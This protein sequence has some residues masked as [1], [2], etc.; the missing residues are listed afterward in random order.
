MSER[1][2][3]LGHQLAEALPAGCNVT[4]HHLSS[5]PT[6]CPALFA[7][8]PGDTPPKTFCESQ[9]LVVSIDPTPC[10]QPASDDDQVLVF[11]IEVLIYC[12]T[13]LTTLF[14][15]KADSS[16]YLHL[17]DAP[18]T[19]TAPLKAIATTFI[20]YLGQE[21]RR[22]GIKTV[23]SL[24]ARAQDQYL[25]PG[26]VENGGKHVLDDRGLIRWWCR[27]LD[28]LLPLDDGEERTL[29]LQGYVLVPGLD[30]H[31]TSTLFPPSAKLDA[32]DRK[33]WLHGHP[34]REISRT[35]T[36]PPR[37]LVP[38]FPDDPKA[39]Y[40]DEL[41]E[42]VSDSLKTGLTQSP[43]KLRR[44]GQWLGIKTLEQF[45]ETM[46]FRQEC[47]S[48]RLVGFIWILYEPLQET[49]RESDWP[50]EHLGKSDLPDYTLPEIATPPTARPKAR[51]K[52]TGPVKVRPPRPKTTLARSEVG[53]P[54]VNTPYY[55]WPARSHG[56]VT[57]NE[58]DY[59]RVHDFLLHLDFANQKIAT[60][61]TRRWV[62]EV[63]V[64]A[65]LTGPSQDW[66]E[67]IRGSKVR[68]LA[69]QSR[70]IKGNSVD[71]SAM[72]KRKQDGRDESSPA[73]GVEAGGTN[74]L[75]TNLVRKKPKRVAPAPV[76]ADAPAAPA[77][78][79]LG[80]GLVRKKAKPTE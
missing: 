22:P 43:S 6:K 3:S 35:P 32:T 8:L 17:L 66:G 73:L 80:R 76:A 29:R 71:A 11:A 59:K 38:H 30:R 26:S 15:S 25:F 75:A 47:S 56:R 62:H 40:L 57:V 41:D 60:E 51:R 34:L 67:H 16:G 49:A 50:H 79:V 14:V 52:L 20:S 5:F 42:E 46:E 58:K 69:A 7:P 74:V 13:E 24:F 39:R 18:K 77:V 19:D 70:T 12:S 4:I 44:G 48:G 10:S 68:G 36:A 45:W 63:A 54:P 28:P 61:S 1:S 55:Q 27:T 64:I 65:E 78:N 33:R 23:I 53:R 9:F 37:C 72:T 21:R 31:E 2:S